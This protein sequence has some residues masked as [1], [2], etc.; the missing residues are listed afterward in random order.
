MSQIN[1]QQITSE[2]KYSNIDVKDGLLAIV[3]TLLEDALISPENKVAI[4]GV[5]GKIASTLTN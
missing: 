5:R 3:D 1:F 2:E 4:A